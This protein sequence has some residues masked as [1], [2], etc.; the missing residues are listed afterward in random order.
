MAYNPKDF[1]YKDSLLSGDPEKVIKGGDFDN[2][3]QA[4][5]RELDAIDGELH[6][7]GG[8]GDLV[9][10][11]P[12]T[13][14]NYARQGGTAT[15]KEIGTEFVNDTNFVSE[16]TNKDLGAESRRW[17]KLWADEVDASGDV[18]IGGDVSIDGALEIHGNII[19]DGGQIV[20]PDG[21]PAGGV[22]AGSN[23]GDV[24]KWNGS[25]WVPTLYKTNDLND[26]QSEAASKD[27]FLI[28]NGSQWI[29]ENFH[30]D[31][32]LEFQGAADLTGPAP[33][34]PANGDLYIN[35]TDGIVD[36]SWGPIAG[37]T[38]LAGN[39]VG[40]SSAKGR[41]Y[42]LGD[43]N[44]AAVTQVRGGD[45]IAV[46]DDEPSR[47]VVGL[48][49]QAQGDIA[50]GVEAHSWGNHSSDISSLESA[51]NQ[52]IDDRKGGDTNLQDQIDDL[53][54]LEGNDISGLQ[55]QITQE[56]QDRKDGDK[57]LQDQITQNA[58]DILNNAD[59]IE[60]N[61]NSIDV[62]SSELNSHSH[63]LDD[64]TDVN[65]GTPARDDLIIWNGSNWVSDGFSFIQTALRFKGGIAPTAAAPA[66]PEGGDLYVF[67]ASGTVSASWGVIADREVQA[68]KFV[69]YAAGS[70]NR[71]FLLGDMAEIGVTNVSPGTGIDV[72]DSR[73]SE[74][75][76]SIDRTEVDKWYEPKFAKNS[77]FNKNFGTAAGAVAEGNHTHSQYLTDFT[78]TDP[79]VP[80]H[81]KSISTTNISNWNSAHG[82]GNHATQGYLKS[83]DIPGTDLST[84]YT[85]TESDNK[86]EPKFT[87]NNAFNKSFG[88]STGTVAQGDHAH[89]Q[90]LTSSNL[91][92]YA[93]EA[94]VKAGYQPK[95]S[96][97]LD[98]HTHSQYASKGDSYTKAEI[99]ALLEGLSVG[100][101]GVN[102]E[103]V[104]HP[105]N[106]GDFGKYPGSIS[107]YAVVVEGQTGRLTK[108][109]TIPN[110]FDF[111]LSG[112][113]CRDIISGA[114]LY[115]MQDSTIDGVQIGQDMNQL[116]VPDGIWPP[117]PI[118]AAGVSRSLGR[119]DYIT[120]KNQFVCHLEWPTFVSGVTQHEFIMFGRLVKTS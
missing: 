76:V 37:K 6:P 54:A 9:H 57:T 115:V 117:L 64:L 4:I 11:P 13:G 55:D 118:S 35:D 43:L 94:W 24:P 30:I 119:G 120:I 86:F 102:R 93:T 45:C 23:I 22:G 52:E 101:D 110:G 71:W 106:L 2:E 19:I 111:V 114:Q 46:N 48:T 113:Q 84:Y 90:Y 12:D 18:H 58:G 10:E 100:G 42:L 70:N 20:D 62:L 92:G 112:M 15:W 89:A 103:W 98:G 47:P 75:V 105:D 7:G 66:S 88:T 79:T 74:P 25:E 107:D 85:K 49:L 28:H 91:S 53:K 96:Y 61:A 39:V 36:A 68:G 21:N 5:K 29:A 38:A 8:D 44:S 95:G 72:D 31:T 51:L 1:G 78:E 109:L 56:I 32:T 87:K 77:A 60:D 50:L 41:W 97:S 99:D 67:D 26:V 80:G 104:A 27:Q 17:N 3:F 108:R 59:N 14:K 34:N 73:P 40:F 65:A 116:L 69:G 83:G 33:V 81:V 63:A 82:W 16:D